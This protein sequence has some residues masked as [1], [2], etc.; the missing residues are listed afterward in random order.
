MPLSIIVLAFQ[1][2]AVNNLQLSLR[3]MA[4]P[5]HASSGPGPVKS[6][7]NGQHTQRSQRKG[8]KEYSLAILSGYYTICLSDLDICQRHMPMAHA[9]D[10]YDAVFTLL[11]QTA[12][13]ALDTGLV[14]SEVIYQRL[15]SS[16]S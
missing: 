10:M 6:T 8:S 14:E 12:L 9:L 3:P 5:R 11:T 2:E 4:K 13:H 15:R 7:S 1:P 16:P